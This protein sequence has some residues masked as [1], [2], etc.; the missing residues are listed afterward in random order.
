MDLK[1]GVRLLGVAES[2]VKGVSENSVLV[3]IVQRADLITDGASLSFPSVGGMDA[4]EKLLQLYNRLDREDVN[5]VCV[6]GSVI[7]WYNV[8][9]FRRFHEMTS[10]PTISLTYEPSEGLDDHFRRACPDDWSKRLEVHRRNGRRE[11]VRL[12]TGYDVFVRGYGIETGDAVK[13]LDA[14]LVQGKYPEP[15]R[16]ARLIS[17]QLSKILMLSE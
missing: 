11:K 14:F 10:T 4:T 1:K 6:S 15:V 3:G 7:S 2:F 13:V 16:V 8:I 12:R 17:H 9:D 5:F